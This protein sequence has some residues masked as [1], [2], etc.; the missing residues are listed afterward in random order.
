MSELL[1]AN[2]VSTI[3]STDSKYSPPFASARAP[4]ARSIDALNIEPETSSR[5]VSGK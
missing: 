3:D 1:V 4:L 2:K 5:Q